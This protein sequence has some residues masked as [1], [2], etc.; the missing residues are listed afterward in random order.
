MQGCTCQCESD[1]VTVWILHLEAACATWAM[2]LSELVP[3]T[4]QLTVNNFL[5][6]LIAIAI[7]LSNWQFVSVTVEVSGISKT[8]GHDG[9]QRYKLGLCL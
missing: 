7:Q 4:C 3:A 9:S 5:E 8:S 2:Y 6:H 1:V